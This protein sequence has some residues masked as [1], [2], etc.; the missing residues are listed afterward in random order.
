M[1]TPVVPGANL[2]ME[3]IASGTSKAKLDRYRI[4]RQ[5]SEQLVAPL[6][7]ADAQLQSMADVSPSKWHLAHTTW[8]FETFILCQYQPGYGRYNETFNYFYNSYYNGIGEQYPRHQRGLISRPSLQEVLE[9]RHWVDQAMQELLLNQANEAVEYLVELGLQHEQQHQEL[10]LT[11]IKHCLFQ[12]PSY[13]AYLPP[14]K[15]LSSTAAGR[16]NAW[17]PIDAGLYS[18]GWEG[19]SFSFDNEKPSHQIYI[20]EFELASTLVSNQE[21]LEFI[22]AGGYQAP[23]HWLA[24]GWSWVQ[25][26]NIDKPLYWLQKDGEWFEYTHYGLQSLV[27]TQTLVHVNF[28]EATAFANWKGLRLPTEFE[29]EVTCRQKG[30]NPDLIESGLFVPAQNDND[31]FG[32]TWQWTSSAYTA[33]PRFKPFSGVAGEYN[34][35]FMSNQFVLRGSSCVTSNKHARISYR[36]F[37]YPHQSWQF[38]GIR[39]AK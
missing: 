12:N 2:A 32:N 31:F 8:F 5:Y 25:Q 1:A 39:L 13:P 29:W 15:H 17:L 22:E 30:I 11:D 35:K 9:Y 24:D 23:D 20:H 16:P 28:Y 3:T 18:V 14:F 10:L 36:N 6:S 7:E 33:Y 21:Y 4:V 19:E 38:S 26:N 37:F 34:G 27:G